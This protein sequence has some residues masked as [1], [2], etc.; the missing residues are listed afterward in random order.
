MFAALPFSL[1][2]QIGGRSVELSGLPLAVHYNIKDISPY[3]NDIAPWGNGYGAALRY[4]FALKNQKKCYVGLGFT[5]APLHLHFLQEGAASP[6]FAITELLTVFYVSGSYA[7]YEAALS[8]K[9]DLIS[10]IGLSFKSAYMPTLDNADNDKVLYYGG[11]EIKNPVVALAPKLW[12]KYAINAS[13]A[14]KVGLW[15]DLPFFQ[16]RLAK[17]KIKSSTE[18]GSIMSGMGYVGV[19][20]AYEYSLGGE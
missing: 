16:T 17:Y 15:A 12:L 11:N 9:I 20:L 4:A 13:N 2:S 7:F 6:D 19:A 8:P 5:H 10:E 3:Q 1:F 14:V 18:S